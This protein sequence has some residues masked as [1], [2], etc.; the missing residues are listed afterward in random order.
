MDKQR[1]GL[2][3]HIPFCAKKCPYCDF[4]SKD[5]GQQEVRRYFPPQI[6][7]RIRFIWEAGRQAFYSL[8]RWKRFF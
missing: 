6:Y 2:Y 3:V 4:F 7:A 8:Q 1:I 5:Y